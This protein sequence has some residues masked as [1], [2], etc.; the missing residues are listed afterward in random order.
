MGK[1]VPGKVSKYMLC[2]NI[3]YFLDDLRTFN[4]AFY[5]L[6]LNLVYLLAAA[7]DELHGADGSKMFL[8]NV[9]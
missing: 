6:Y 2:A 4:A 8:S 5:M 7:R 3:L 9:C 1:K